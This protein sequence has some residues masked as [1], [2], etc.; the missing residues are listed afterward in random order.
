MVNIMLAILYMFLV[1]LDFVLAAFNFS[2]ESKLPKFTRCFYIFAG[3][4]C[5]FAGLVCLFI[6]IVNIAAF[7]Y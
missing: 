5:I 7:L 1:I 6:S 2:E 4:F 3:C